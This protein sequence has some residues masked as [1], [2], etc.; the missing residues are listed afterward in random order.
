[1]TT[2]VSEISPTETPTADANA[3][4]FSRPEHAHHSISIMAIQFM[5][6][7]H[8]MNSK[9]HQEVIIFMSIFTSATF[10]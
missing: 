4:T 10:T 9:R 5:Q 8:L 2:T 1:M 6:I 3:I 7:F